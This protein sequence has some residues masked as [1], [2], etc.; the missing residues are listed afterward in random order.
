MTLS[1]GISAQVT[2]LDGISA[3]MTAVDGISAQMTVVDGISSQMTLVDGISAGIRMFLSLA[4]F[5]C[6]AHLICSSRLPSLYV[7]LLC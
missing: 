4:Q 2:L 3:Q 5:V 1:D 7:P 6:P